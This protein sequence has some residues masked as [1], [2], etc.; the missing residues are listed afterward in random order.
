MAASIGRIS[1]LLSLPA[2]ASVLLRTRKIRRANATNTEEG[3]KMGEMGE[4][5]GMMHFADISTQ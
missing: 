4:I 1:Y 5:G 2:L 3:S